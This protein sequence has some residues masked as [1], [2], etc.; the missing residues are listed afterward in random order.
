MTD[1]EKLALTLDNAIECAAHYCALAPE[2]DALTLVQVAGAEL[3][4][5]R[6]IVNEE[7]QVSA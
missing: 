6:Q 7:Q 4:A 3:M 2:G 1:A 5:A